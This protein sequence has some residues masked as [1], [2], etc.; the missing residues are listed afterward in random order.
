MPSRAELK[1]K[2]KEQIKGKIGILFAIF[3]IFLAIS[4]VVGLIPILGGIVSLLISGPVALSFS[5]IFLNVTKGGKPKIGDLFEGFKYFGKS[6][7]LLLL[8]GIFTFLWSLLLIVPGIIKA[9]SYSQSFYILANNPNMTAREALK[10]SMKIMNGH[11]WEYFV[12]E[13]SFILWILLVMVTFGIAL[14]YVYPYMEA[15]LANYYRALSGN[16][17]EAPAVAGTTI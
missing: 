8:I 13:L 11:K 17:A 10:E 5:M 4:V 6:L 1:I 9:F 12:L 16:T 14:I 7:A 15:T 3:L 2:A